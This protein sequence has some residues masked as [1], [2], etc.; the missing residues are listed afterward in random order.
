MRLSLLSIV[1]ALLSTGCEAPQPEPIQTREEVVRTT[2]LEPELEPQ[3]DIPA[4]ILMSQSEIREDLGEPA[5]EFRPTE[6]QRELGIS[7]TLEYQ[8]GNTTLSIDFGRDGAVQEIFL[9]D[10]T[11]GRSADQLFELGNL[12]QSGATYKTSIQPWINPALARS[13]RS[14]EVAGIHVYP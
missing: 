2:E 7:A 12:E 11:E 10:A 8:R 1:L 14:A 13:N 3:F 5:S 9:S 4:L 6:R